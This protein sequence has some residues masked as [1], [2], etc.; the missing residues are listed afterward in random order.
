VLPQ[1]GSIYLTVKF[2]RTWSALTRLRA[3]VGA[4]RFRDLMVDLPDALDETGS[5]LS[6]S[7]PSSMICPAVMTFT[8]FWMR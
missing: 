8:H 1:S 7:S 5:P 6:G 3:Q 4:E 2:D